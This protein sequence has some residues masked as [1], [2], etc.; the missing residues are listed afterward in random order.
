MAADTLSLR[1]RIIEK[2]RGY[3]GKMSV[4]T[5]E[6]VA[7]AIL[8]VVEQAIQQAREDERQA[9][10]RYNNLLLKAVAEQRAALA[11]KDAQLKE[12]CELYDERIELMAAELAEKDAQIA[13][14][15]E[16][17]RSLTRVRDTMPK[18]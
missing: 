16:Q 13:A 12:E 4:F 6:Q 18:V 8:P 17:I 14:L 9:S 10:A 3:F 7:D 2:L 15:Q 11:E 1:E 5:P